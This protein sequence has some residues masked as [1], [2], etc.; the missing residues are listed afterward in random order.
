MANKEG[1]IS[2]RLQEFVEKMEITPDYLIIPDA[3]V[4]AEARTLLRHVE[5]LESTF[6]YLDVEAHLGEEKLWDA[7]ESLFR[8]IRKQ[9][10]AAGRRIKE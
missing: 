10:L 8:I 2:S 3:D 1:E 9:L 7:L 4:S 6:K 5:N